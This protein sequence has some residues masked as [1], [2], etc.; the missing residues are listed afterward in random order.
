MQSLS[1]S[2]SKDLFPTEKRIKSV[3]LLG[4]HS[5]SNLIDWPLFNVIS[6]LLFEESQV[7]S[8]FNNVD[9]SIGIIEDF[10]KSISS[11]VL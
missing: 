1:I 4:K 11:W 3:L 10:S 8:E 9:D 5:Q 7:D 6:Y 2:L